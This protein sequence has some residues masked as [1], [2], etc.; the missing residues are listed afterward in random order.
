MAIIV[1]EVGAVAVS[2]LTDSQLP[3]VVVF[4]NTWKGTEPILVTV[5]V[6]WVVKLPEEVKAKEVG[7]T[8][9]RLLPPELETVSVTVMVADCVELA[10]TAIWPV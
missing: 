1:I 8:V 9:R 2:V 4:V 7:L 5:T 10:T 3:P 6:D